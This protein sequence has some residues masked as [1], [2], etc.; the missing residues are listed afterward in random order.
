MLDENALSREVIGAAIEVHSLI[1]PGMLESVYQ[2]CLARELELRGIEV[3]QEVPI[4]VNYKGL[5][6]SKAFYADLIVE[7]SLVLELK[8]VDRVIDEHKAQLLT[9]LRWTDLRLGLL[10]N[11]GATRMKQ[12]IT[13]IVNQL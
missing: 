1:G 7:G 12:G 6:I 5:T 8:S 13:R 3:E 2:Q 4:G 10:L 9:Y 11:F